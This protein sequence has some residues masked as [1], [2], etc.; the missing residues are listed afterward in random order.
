MNNYM[1]EN[2]VLFLGGREGVGAV[3][4][5]ANTILAPHLQQIQQT[6]Q[7][8]QKQIAREQRHR[9]DQSVGQL[10]PDYKQI[11]DLPEWKKWLCQIDVLS[12]RVRQILLDEAIRAGNAQRVKSIF[13]AFRHDMGAAPARGASL[14]RAG[15]S[16]Q[17][18]PFYTRAAIKQM[19]ENRRKGLYADADWAAAEADLFRAQQE[20]RV[21]TVPN[22]L[23]K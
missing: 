20:N 1:D 2:D 6:Q 12:G 8:L 13:D 21:E 23:S 10:V 7:E 9:L 18:L 16:R 19:Y 14:A 15:R 4:R 17:G 5:V 11:D 3:G 22:F